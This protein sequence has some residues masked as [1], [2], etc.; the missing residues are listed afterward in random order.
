LEK[1]LQI[2]TKTKEA[3]HEMLVTIISE[4]AGKTTSQI[5]KQEVRKKC[6]KY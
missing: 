2:E 1:R 6:K 5:I 3:Y 4:A